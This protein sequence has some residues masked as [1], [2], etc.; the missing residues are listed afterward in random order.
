MMEPDSPF[1]LAVNHNRSKNGQWFKKPPLG[2][3]SL[4]KIVP[5][6]CKTNGIH[7]KFSN[8]S[9]RKKTCTDLLHADVNPIII[10]QLTG[11]KNVQSLNNYAVAS[12]NMQKEMCKI[13]LDDKENLSKNPVQPAASVSAPTQAID[14][15]TEEMP[16]S[17]Q[18]SVHQPS[19]NNVLKRLSSNIL[20]GST[21][22][23][24]VNINMNFNTYN[25]I[26]NVSEDADFNVK[27]PR[28]S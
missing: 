24:T 14:S 23:G 2:E 19:Q 21:F 27:V 26:P 7:G 1:F 10:Q 17:S 18:V 20:T 9:L 8:H 22:T 6:I 5:S 3:H 11:H 28:L 13:L 4:A 12:H 16:L 25:S 15:V